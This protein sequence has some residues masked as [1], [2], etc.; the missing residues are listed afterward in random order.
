MYSVFMRSNPWILNIYTGTRGYA[1]A[2]LKARSDGEHT[3]TSAPSPRTD[4]TD[5][6]PRRYSA[7]GSRQKF[8]ESAQPRP[9]WNVQAE[10]HFANH[11]NALFQPLEF[12]QEAAR[13]CLT[14]GSHPTSINGHNA[15]MTLLGWSSTFCRLGNVA[16][17]LVVIRA[18]NPG[19]IPPAFPQYQQKP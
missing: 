16:I 3:S 14:H 12:S 8:G 17:K 18:Q 15:G 5:G 11:L 7:W 2:L 19:I 9:V 13:R 1:Q 10:P 4:T 6:Y